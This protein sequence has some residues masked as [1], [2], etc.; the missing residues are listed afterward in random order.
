MGKW[1]VGLMFKGLIVNGLMVK[2]LNGTGNS[3]G[4]LS[5][6]GSDHFVFVVM[7]DCFV[8]RNDGSMMIH[9]RETLPLHPAG[10]NPFNPL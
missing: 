10:S 7:W 2:W 1:L 6:N 4:N 3:E 8:P 5:I 9:N